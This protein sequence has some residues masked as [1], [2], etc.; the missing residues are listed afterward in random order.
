MENFTPISALI[1]GGL[2]GLSAALLLLFKGRV[3]G[4]SGIVGGVLVPEKGD[5]DWR[6]V[7]VVGLILGGFL[8]QWLGGDVSEIKSVV[9]QPMLIAA[10]LL[11]GIG[12]TVGTGC[13]S[14]HGICGIA[15]F[16]GRSMTATVSFMVT[17]IITVALVRH[18]FGG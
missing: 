5:V 1:G 3:A 8:Y 17:G 10:G 12:T 6:I 2:I 7:F 14:G 11:V 16:S 13:T 18:V 9:S 4:I 15:R